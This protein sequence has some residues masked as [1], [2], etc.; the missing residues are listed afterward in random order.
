MI[1]VDRIIAREQNSLI[2][3]FHRVRNRSLVDARTLC[4]TEEKTGFLL[5]TLVWLLVVM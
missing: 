1:E 4:F 3:L 2:S 5:T